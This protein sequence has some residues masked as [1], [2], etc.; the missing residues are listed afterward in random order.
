MYN[1]SPFMS[2]KM[3]ASKSI[4]SIT[5]C[6]S[7]G[8][9]HYYILIMLRLFFILVVSYSLLLEN[10]V[11]HI[12]CYYTSIHLVKV[13]SSL[14]RI[15]VFIAKVAYLLNSPIFELDCKSNAYVVLLIASVVWSLNNFNY[16]LCFLVSHVISI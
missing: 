4:P 15:V 12:V 7:L 1:E 8:G 6:I 9:V 13:M 11:S 10:N 16:H 14:S 2:L 3:N 5:W